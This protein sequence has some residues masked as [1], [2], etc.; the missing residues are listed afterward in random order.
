[1]GVNDHI[2]AKNL[3][4]LDEIGH[5]SA[6]KGLRPFKIS[7]ICRYAGLLQLECM[8]LDLGRSLG[9][10]ITHYRAKYYIKG[11]NGFSWELRPG[12]RRRYTKG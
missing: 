7:T 12:L 8:R 9:Q 3:S 2:L 6:A 11:Y 5:C 4:I 10:Y 1:M